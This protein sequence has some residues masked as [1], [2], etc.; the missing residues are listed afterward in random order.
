MKASRSSPIALPIHP[1]VLAYYARNLAHFIQSI[2]LLR[3]L[4]RSFNWTGHRLRILRYTFALLVLING[5][6]FPG[7]WTW[8][9][10]W[11]V[12]KV[13]TRYVGAWMLASARYYSRIVASTHANR[14]S[15][16]IE[17]MESWLASVTPI[18]DHP[19]HWEGKYDTWLGFDDSDFNMHMS[20]SSYPKILDF[21]RTKASLE[22]FPHFL[23]VGGHVALSSTHFNFIREIPLFAKYQIR[24]SIAAWDEK[25]ASIL[26]FAV[27]WFR[28]ADHE[29]CYLVARFVTKSDN[30]H[31]ASHVKSG[32]PRILLNDNSLPLALLH[33]LEGLTLRTIAV[34]RICFKIGRITVPPAVVFATNGMSVGPRELNGALK[35]SAREE[36]RQ[37][38]LKEEGGEPTLLTEDFSLSNPPPSWTHHARHLITKMHGGSEGKLKEFY[39]GGWKKVHGAHVRSGSD[40]SVDSSSSETDIASLAAPLRYGNEIPW[41]DQAMGVGGPMDEERKERLKVCRKLVGGLEGVRGLVA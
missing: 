22:L 19:F 24:L 5:R 30:K 18:G 11:C 2:N 13:R 23:R 17:E 4:S 40:S 41:W 35:I 34:S 12:I 29:Q 7:A 14:L 33:D 36:E 26:P 20:N 37:E 31:Q 3:Y 32:S 6:S 25:W 39:R 15:R 1:R 28:V 16:R 9:V 21:A 8:R 27:D 10:L 38:G